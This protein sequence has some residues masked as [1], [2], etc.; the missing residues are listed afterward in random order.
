M[1]AHPLF[2]RAQQVIAQ[3]PLVE[4]NLGTLK[5]GANRYGELFA[6]IVALDQPVAVLLAIKAGRGERA[7]VR[8][9]RTI[10]PTQS[11]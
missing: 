2:G 11:L 7:T 1:G 9:T 6:A 10:G 4:R 3:Q 8:A 5:H